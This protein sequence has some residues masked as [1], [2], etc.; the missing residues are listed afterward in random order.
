MDDRGDGTPFQ[1]SGR[2]NPSTVPT[3]EEY[4]R[5]SADVGRPE[6]QLLG[7]RVF[8]ERNERDELWYSPDLAAVL[9]AI[10]YNKDGSISDVTE[11]ISVTRG[12]PS[13][14]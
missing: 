1:S 2:V 4:A 10:S 6:A 5:A 7:Y 11:A 8:I 13:D 14:L 12:E 3:V 9:K